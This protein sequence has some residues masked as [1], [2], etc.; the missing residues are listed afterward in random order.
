MEVG[1][2]DSHT[3]PTSWATSALVIPPIRNSATS[4][5]SAAAAHS[6]AT[7]RGGDADL[8]LVQDVVA[9]PVPGPGLVS[10]SASNGSA[11]KTST[12]RSRITSH[13]RVVLRL[14]LGYP[15]HV[16]EQQFLGVRR[17]Q[18]GVLESGPVHHDL[19][20]SAHLRVHSKWHADHLV[21]F[22]PLSRLFG[23][24]GWHRHIYAS[25][26]GIR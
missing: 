19:A 20:Q 1:S 5:A 4:A 12:P 6:P 8:T 11:W 3:S 25:D 2:A 26:P 14:G 10:A 18:T 17:G 24:A 22:R 15:E 7:L 21:I 23:G 13:E 9:D 16:V